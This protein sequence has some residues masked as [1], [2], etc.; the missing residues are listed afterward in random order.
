MHDL[1]P[2]YMWRDL[3]VSSEDEKSPFYETEYS[4][5]EFTNQIYNHLIHPQWDFFGSNTLY[6][7]I[8]FADYDEGFAIIELIGEWN[9]A[10]DNDIMYLKRDILEHMID[11]GINRFIIIGENVLNFH[12]SDD[13]YY[14]ELDQDLDD[15]G[16]VVFLNFRDHVLEEFRANNLDYFVHFGGELDNL[17]W[18]KLQPPQLY[19]VVNRLLSRRLGN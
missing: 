15:D 9:D 1:E 13:S 17:L 8:L 12:A 4:E 14:E 2:Y 19:D 16:W 18:R 7:K 11:Y 5:F 6:M 3:Y 10:V